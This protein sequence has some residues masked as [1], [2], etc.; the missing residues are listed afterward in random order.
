MSNGVID[1]AHCEWC[2]KG[3]PGPK[4]LPL[5]YVRLF[6][7]VQVVFI[8]A[9]GTWAGV[10]LVKKV[11]TGEPVWA[12]LAIMFGLAMVACAMYLAPKMVRDWRGSK[13][14]QRPCT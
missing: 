13:R 7:I 6:V 8:L 14:E 4:P 2:A 1:P 9:V 10:Q 12:A 3:Q 11:A 5:S